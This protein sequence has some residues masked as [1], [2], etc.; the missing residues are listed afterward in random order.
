MSSY[1]FFG[2]RPGLVLKGW[3]PGAGEVL[4][5]DVGQS[6]SGVARN[7]NHLLGEGVVVGRRLAHERG[8]LPADEHF[9]CVDHSQI[10]DRT[11]KGG[12]SEDFLVKQILV[13][14]IP[15]PGLVGLLAWLAQL[16]FE[17]RFP[18]AGNGFQLLDAE[19][20]NLVLTG[21]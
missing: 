5:G 17:D 14:Q 6:E 3:H 20:E 11:R 19:K 21:I 15:S 2:K 13:L 12:R 18:L 4:D 8:A 9:D 16:G 10:S 7:A 1:L